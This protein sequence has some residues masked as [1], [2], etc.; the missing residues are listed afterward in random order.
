MLRSQRAHESPSSSL[1]R[2]WYQASRSRQSKLSGYRTV[3]SWQRKT[4]GDTGFCPQTASLGGHTQ[5]EEAQAKAVAARQVA[6]LRAAK[7]QMQ[8]LRFDRALQQAV[9]ALIEFETIYFAELALVNLECNAAT[10]S[11]DQVP[12]LRE[13]IDLVIS[14]FLSLASR[15]GSLSRDGHIG[16]LFGGGDD[17]DEDDDDDD[18]ICKFN[19]QADEFEELPSSVDLLE[20]EDT[21]LSTSEKAHL[22]AWMR[23]TLRQRAV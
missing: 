5:V 9:A 23:T 3:N 7:S 17:D 19:M 2:D 11:C 15:G 1:D 8:F 4:S 20:D 16:A 6:A 12:I 18:P 21:F 22:E 10:A 14:Q 13:K